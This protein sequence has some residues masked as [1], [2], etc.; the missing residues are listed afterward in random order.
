MNEIAQDLKLNNPSITLYAFHLRNSS[1]DGLEV[2]VAE[3]PQLWEQLVEFG[4]KFHI[5]ELQNLRQQLVCYQD[6]KY[7]PQAEDLISIEHLILLRDRKKCLNFQLIAQANAVE[8]QGMLCPIRLHDSYAIDLTLSSQDT[9]TLTQLSAFN[10]PDLLLP[11][12]IKASLGQTLLLFGQPTE[13]QESYQDLADAYVAQILS[14]NSSV[15]LVGT[16]YLLGNPFFEY[17]SAHTDPAQKLHILVWLKC[18]E[19]NSVEMDTVAER[20]MYLLWCRRKIQYVYHQSRWCDHQARQLYGKLENYRQHFDRISQKDANKQLHLKDLSAE[21]RQTELDYVSYLGELA[22][23]ENTI[24]INEQNYGNKLEN[25]ELLPNTNLP[26]CQQ[27]LL[28][29]RNKL[30]LQIKTDISFLKRGQARL[31]HLKVIIQETIVAEPVNNDMSGLP[32]E[33]NIRLRDALLHCNQFASTRQLGAVFGTNESLR[34]WRSGIP[35]ADSLAGRVNLTIDYLIDKFHSSGENGLVILVHSLADSVDPADNLHRILGELAD[36]LRLLL[37]PKINTDNSKAK[38][39]QNKK[40]SFNWLHL[41]DLHQGMKAQDWLWPGVREIFFQDLERLHDQCGPWD[42]VLFTGDLT[43]TGSAQEFHK[44]DELMNDLWEHFHKLGSS[45]KLLAIPGNHDLVRP[46]PKEPTVRLLQQ[47]QTHPDIQE[48]FW[49][50]A[51]SPYRQVVMS[52]FKNYTDWWERQPNKVE[53]LN[54]GILPGDFSATVEKDGAKLG[55]VGLNTSF[56]QL[57]GGDYEGKLALHPKQFHQACNNKNGA[58]WAKQH[59]ACLLLTHHPSGW[60]NPDSQRHLKSEITAHGRFAV[61]LCGHLHEALSGESIE[62]GAD[63]RRIWQ[64]RSLF[65]LEYH[66][67]DTTAVERLHGYTAAKID[68][69]INKGN[70]I[71]WPREA[72]LQGGQRSIVQDLSFV[73][74]DDQHTKP[75]EFDLLRSYVFS[76]SD[77][78][79]QNTQSVN[80]ER[81]LLIICAQSLPQQAIGSDDIISGFNSEMKGRAKETVSLNFTNL[82]EGGVFTDPERAIQELTDP[83]GLLKSTID[84]AGEVDL[85]FHGL[86]HIP[87]LFLMGHLV[88]DRLPVRLFD[89]HPANSNWAWTDDGQHF[90]PL[91]VLRLPIDQR[92]QKKDVVLRISVSYLVSSDWTMIVAPSEAIEIDLKVPS[93]QRSI[94]RSEKQTREYGKVFRRILDQIAQSLPPGQKIHLFYAGPVAL[95]FHLGQQVSENI[96]PPIIVWNYK[97]GYDWGINLTEAYNRR[98]ATIRPSITN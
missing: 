55:I 45:P 47:W 76:D 79:S 78:G 29:I 33:I 38:Q 7:C 20:L 36:E 86:A 92:W 49:E 13:S 93:P 14:D 3:A 95:A 63:A 97:Q 35:E 1:N 26:F 80:S 41:T 61:H 51:D 91:E 23:H 40:C 57:T 85:V 50:D 60:L 65:G 56:L 8:L 52:A 67:S 17:E 6:N 39:K 43:Q 83:Q 37:L 89:F 72:R 5:P 22:E 18:Q 74:T 42:L 64:S 27:F 71:F 77:T 31:Q 58:E 30:L 24:A 66:S 94:V 96:H 73:L 2:T 25:L 44:L 16:G 4:N 54:Q 19:M 53:N 62:G 11:P 10:F 12:Q 90:P 82:V 32:S 69:S 28:Y 34:L 70:L 46:N 15:E 9:F 68:V 84:R 21:I 98:Q 87:L 48:E 59:N 75:K 88:S 81:P